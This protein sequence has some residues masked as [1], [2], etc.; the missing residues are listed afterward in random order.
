MIKEF[1]KVN[2]ESTQ[3]FKSV[4]F[5]CDNHDQFY[6]FL[7][8]CEMEGIIFSN[9]ILPTPSYLWDISSKYAIIIESNR[10]ENKLFL[11]SYPFEFKNGFFDTELVDFTELNRDFKLNELLG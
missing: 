3:R 9:L 7:N 8:L 10:M 11:R 4:G 1:L 5:I 2:L 6:H